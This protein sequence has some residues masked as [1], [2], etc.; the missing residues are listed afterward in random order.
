MRT[1]GIPAAPLAV[2]GLVGM[3]AVPWSGPALPGQARSDSARTPVPSGGD[4]LVL[5]A[6]VV[7]PESRTVT[8][9]NVLVENGRVAAFP[10]DVRPGYDGETVDTEG[11]WLLPALS[12][13]HAHSFGNVGIGG[14]YERLGAAAAARR[15]LRAGV[16]RY[17]DLFSD[18]D[19]IFAV[20]NRQRDAGLPGAE[21]L[22]AGPCLTA[23]DGH[24]SE[25]GV[26]TRI[27]DTPAEAREEVTALAAEEPD[28][29]KVVYDH[30]D[31]GFASRPTIDE[32]TLRA[33]I[34][35]ASDLGLTT[36]VHVGTWGDV[37]DAVE[38]GASAVTHTPSGVLPADLPALLADRGVFHIPTLAAQ[39]EY[40]RVVDEPA[41]LE[42]PLL[43]VL[44]GDD[45]IASYREPPSE[46][47]RLALWVERQRAESGGYMDAVAQ[48]AEAGVTILTGTDAG[49]PAVFHGY[50]VHREL[51]LLVEAGLS[52]WEALAAST[53]DAGRFLRRE[54]GVQVGDEAS[55]LILAGSPVEE[56]ANTKRIHQIIQRGEV[57]WPE[58]DRR[59]GHQT[60][61]AS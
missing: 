42:D 45:V 35:T 23:T 34:R 25:Y 49:N 13:M 50:S 52:E 58:E 53:S 20:R 44:V 47:G 4:L 2:L 41:L 3:L 32:E 12:D 1:P 39:V 29:V 28:V 24:C 21:I 46:G 30:A 43:E 38:A 19:A 9:K 61:T 5:D 10:E 26:P 8:R 56:I 51:A 33:V 59:V 60:D 15:A 31:Y 55:F 40:A 6:R 22:A 37:R 7:D 48:L 14:P 36:V 11:R 17:L 27:V 16:G 54:L 57:V 18:E